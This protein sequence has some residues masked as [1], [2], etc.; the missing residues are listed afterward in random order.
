MVSP[1]QRREGVDLA[2][3]TNSISLRRACGLM[4]ISTSVVRNRALMVMASCGVGLQRWRPSVA[5][6]AIDE[7]T[8][9]CAGRDGW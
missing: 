6:L 9:C 5:A 4:H 8:S 1:Q 2:M 7:S 3:A